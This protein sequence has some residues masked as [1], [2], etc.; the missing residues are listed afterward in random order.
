M[1]AGLGIAVILAALIL[2]AASQT[3][4]LPCACSVD[5]HKLKV[6]QLWGSG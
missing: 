1:I 6:Y 3:G 4:L 5:Q 2:P